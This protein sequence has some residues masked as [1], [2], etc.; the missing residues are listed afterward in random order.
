MEC[1]I[2]RKGVRDDKKDVEVD[3]NTFALCER[4]NELA[5]SIKDLTLRLP[6]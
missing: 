2:K 1:N 4:L 5:Q 3:E 6:K